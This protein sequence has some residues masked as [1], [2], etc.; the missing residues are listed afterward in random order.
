MKEITIYTEDIIPNCKY[1][2][3]ELGRLDLLGQLL[4]TGYNIRIP[5]KT[6]TPQDLEKSIKNFVVCIRGFCYSNTPIT[7]SLLALYSL[8]GKKQVAEANKLLNSIGINLIIASEVKPVVE[9]LPESVIETNY[10]KE[11]TL[12]L[13]NLTRTSWYSCSCGHSSTISDIQRHN[14]ALCLACKLPMSTEH[15]QQVLNK[16][17]QG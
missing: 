17:P 13:T 2:C 15:I 10:W 16:F 8:P 12:S 7:L 14:E 4:F 5:Y 3:D 11:P 9:K 6:R 1:M